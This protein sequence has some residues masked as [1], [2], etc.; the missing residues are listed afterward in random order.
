[1]QKQSHASL[2]GIGE[3]RCRC[4]ASWY[5]PAR[6]L[7]NRCW[8][9]CT[10]SVWSVWLHAANPLRLTSLD[11]KRGRVGITTHTFS[12]LSPGKSTT[13]MR[14]H[15]L[16]SKLLH[17]LTLVVRF[18]PLTQALTCRQDFFRAVSSQDSAWNS[19]SH[20]EIDPGSYYP[21]PRPHRRY[22][23]FVIGV[24]QRTG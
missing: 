13:H 22:G 12:G 5:A 7:R 21:S 19:D 6:S 2:R 15:L 10:M 17:E 9:R 23:I 16:E 8:F 14:V 11:P 1:M 4:P 24:K 20:V 3:S 18:G